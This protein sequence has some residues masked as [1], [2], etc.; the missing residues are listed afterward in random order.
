MTDPTWH[1]TSGSS[2]KSGSSGTPAGLL[3]NTDWAALGHAYT[4]SAT[5]TPMRLAQLLDPDPDVRSHALGQLDMSVLH[6]GSLYSAT[7]PAALYIAS[8]LDDPRARPSV[9]RLIEFLGTV[10]ESAAWGESEIAETTAEIDESNESDESEAADLAAEERA[11][12]ECREIRP[13]LLAAIEPHLFAA[14]ETIHVAAATAVEWLLAAPDLAGRREDL[15]AVL[16]QSAVESPDRRRRA[17]T[18]LILGDWGLRPDLLLQD[19]DQA[20]RVCAALAPAYS[21]DREVGRVLVEA[22]EDTRTVDGWFPYLLPTMEVRLVYEIVDS[23]LLEHDLTWDEMLPAA[24]GVA[25]DGTTESVSSGWGPFLVRGFRGRWERGEPLTAA[26]RA[27]LAAIVDNDDCWR[28]ER[29]RVNPA[30]SEEYLGARNRD[31]WFTRAGLPTDRD[32][33]RILIEA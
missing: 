31:Y 17:T 27:Y 11:T 3:T 13:A 24:L 23:L 2:G 19:P 25:R 15:V 16:Q 4:D 5:D 14:D 33:L 10:A 7:A 21:R 29:N 9:A 22:L 32:R 18:A 30:A 6:Q 26:Q 1:L 12:Q 20:V 28:A 8:I